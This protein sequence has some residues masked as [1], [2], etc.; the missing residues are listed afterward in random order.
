MLQRVL[1]LREDCFPDYSQDHFERLL[2]Q[3]ARIVRSQTISDPG[4]RQ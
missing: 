2:Q 1:A 3:Q 4:R